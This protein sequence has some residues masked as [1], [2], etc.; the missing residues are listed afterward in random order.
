[1]TE[2]LDLGSPLLSPHLFLFLLNL[3]TAT[4]QNTMILK[5]CYVTAH[6]YIHDTLQPKP[7]E[8]YSSLHH[9][10]S[11]VRICS[12]TAVYLIS[13]HLDNSER[14]CQSF[15]RLLKPD[16]VFFF[17]L[18]AQPNSRSNTINQP[19]AS[20]KSSGLVSSALSR[21]SVLTVQ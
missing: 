19:E 15:C 8:E 13:A 10:R 1:M 11:C 16:G 9:V 18:Q 20:R 17:F 4:G 12:S 7:L 2:T 3:N 21:Q 14:I 6:V 5:L